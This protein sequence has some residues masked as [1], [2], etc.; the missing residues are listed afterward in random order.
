MKADLETQARWK[1]LVET[2]LQSGKSYKDFCKEHNIQVYQLQYWVH[3]DKPKR[4][5]SSS[6]AK[7]EIKRESANSMMKVWIRSVAIEIPIDF[8]EASLRRVI[9][10]VDSI[11]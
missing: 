11:V 4:V 3:K 6:F 2:L 7:V 8:D 1:T 5:E 9:Q 10:V